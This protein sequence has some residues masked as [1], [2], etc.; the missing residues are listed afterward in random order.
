MIK[1]IYM[2]R[3]TIGRNRRTGSFA[4]AI[5]VKTSKGVVVGHDV[6]VDGPSRISQQAGL[7]P[8]AGGVTVWITTHAPVRVTVKQRLLDDDHTDIA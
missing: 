2:N 7:S 6:Q 8:L 4:P 5:C 1:R 3:H